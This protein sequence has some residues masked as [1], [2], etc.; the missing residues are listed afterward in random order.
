MSKKPRENAHSNL[1][2]E[3][4]MP[5]E[6]CRGTVH[7]INGKKA[8]TPFIPEEGNSALY[9]GKTIVEPLA[10]RIKAVLG[11]HEDQPQNIY[12]A[13]FIRSA[14]TQLAGRRR[15]GEKINIVLARCMS[16]IFNGAQDV[17]KALTIEEQR[18]LILKIAKK[19]GIP[20]NEIRI[21]ELE[22]ILRHTELFH[23]LRT[24]VDSRTGKFDPELAFGAEPHK[25]EGQELFRWPES[26]SRDIAKCLYQAYRAH[27]EF[28]ERF[29]DTVPEGLTSKRTEEY[30]DNQQ[31]YYSLAEVAC[32]LADLHHGI[33][34]QSGSS[35][36]ACYDKIIE[37]VR[38]GRKGKFKKYQELEPLFE[39]FKGKDFHTLHLFTDDGYREKKLRR[40]R[41]RTKIA[42]IGTIGLAS[43]STAV[44]YEWH[45]E[46]RDR[47]EQEEQMRE[48][49][50]Q[51]TRHIRYRFESFL[52]E[53]KDNVDITLRI[54]DRTL[55]R[56]QERYN[57]RALV[58]RELRPL[59]VEF[60]L[61][62]VYLLQEA[63]SNEAQVNELADLFVKKHSLFLSQKGVDI[64]RPY[65]NFQ[66]YLEE[67]SAAAEGNDDFE[68]RTMPAPPNPA[69]MEG[70]DALNN[71]RVKKIGTFTPSENYGSART[72]YRY[73]KDGKIHII[74]R[75]RS[76]EEPGTDDRVFTAKEGKVLAR[77]FLVG[78][79][80]FD[81]LQV[82][83]FRTILR[84][85]CANDYALALNER[86]RPAE[87]AENP[88]TFHYKD[89]LGK[90]EYFL[91]QSYFMDKTIH[92]YTDIILARRPG[93]SQY[94]F[95]IGMEVARKFCDIMQAR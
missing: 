95:E 76:K 79:R 29:R 48:K 56:T 87:S 67:I 73:E 81:T 38:R 60:L 7:K 80:K 19:E 12:S 17:E 42:A 44:G 8:D 57:F 47:K 13:E 84:N 83:D 54:T 78:M 32:R 28:A 34:F 11:W 15:V 21:I 5:L 49:I 89:S 23:A 53:P 72:L 86:T 46:M 31:N 66:P 4:T 65:A 35:R 63:N 27:P 45:T 14:L 41:A 68:V 43:L 70:A 10:A 51:G 58:F 62:N 40:T 61:D 92:H 36:Q 37:E 22:K 18:Q 9:I 74:G 75:D 2:G 55:N 26:L 91:Q 3:A 50:R 20:E 82:Y 64:S 52:M 39:L 71:L 16:E 69:N 6:L 94:T 90:F 25:E 1:I 59:M 77:K 33:N 30:A 88:F 93:E 85:M 24:A